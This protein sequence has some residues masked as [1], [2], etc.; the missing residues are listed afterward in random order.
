M[1]GRL[2]VQEIVGCCRFTTGRKPLHPDQLWVQPLCFRQHSSIC[3]STYLMTAFVQCISIISEII[4]NST[5]LLPYENRIDL[6]SCEWR[7]WT[8]KVLMT[9]NRWISVENTVGWSAVVSWTY[10][11]IFCCVLPRYRYAQILL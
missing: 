9:S 6:G 5:L 3:C 8:A 1:L 10:T 4:P 2:Y 11:A 7:S